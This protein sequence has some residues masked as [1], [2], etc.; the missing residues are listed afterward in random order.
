MWLLGCL[1]YCVFTGGTQYLLCSMC[2]YSRNLF[3]SDQ[4][5]VGGTAFFYTLYRMYWWCYNHS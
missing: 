5:R 3:E 2:E 4:I 1:A